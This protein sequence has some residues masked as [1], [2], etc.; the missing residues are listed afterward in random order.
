MVNFI[1]MLSFCLMFN[2]FISLCFLVF[3]ICCYEN[4]YDWYFFIRSWIWFLLFYFRRWPLLSNINSIW[5]LIIPFKAF[6]LSLLCFIDCNALYYCLFDCLPY[7]LRHWFRPCCLFSFFKMI[8]L[9]VPYIYGCLWVFCCVLVTWIIWRRDRL[10]DANER[11][12]SERFW[13]YNV[14]FTL[15]KND[16]SQ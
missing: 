7:K 5:M 15:K 4:V 8:F 9:Y 16:S 2:F 12:L 6:N 3:S 1:W 11:S 14:P 13:I 10:D